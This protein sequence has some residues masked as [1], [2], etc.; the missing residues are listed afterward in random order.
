MNMISKMYA[1]CQFVDDEKICYDQYAKHIIMYTVG[2]C[3][4][5]DELHR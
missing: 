5:Q 3:V 1:V 2:M 4:F